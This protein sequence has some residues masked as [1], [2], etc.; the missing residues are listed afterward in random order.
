MNEWRVGR[1]VGGRVIAC[2]GRLVS[3]RE[4]P[5]FDFDSLVTNCM[6][7]IAEPV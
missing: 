3:A 1:W 7:L 4:N 5:D 2:A 6:F